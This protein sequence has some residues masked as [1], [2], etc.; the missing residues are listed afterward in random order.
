LTDKKKK[1]K[2]RRLNP[3][4]DAA[5]IRESWKIFQIMAEFV[6]GFEKLAKIKIYKRNYCNKKK[7]KKKITPPN[8]RK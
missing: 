2:L 3:V 5:L 1:R 4:N 7:K 8:P 6:E